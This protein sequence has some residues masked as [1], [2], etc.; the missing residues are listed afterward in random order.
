VYGYVTS[1]A[2]TVYLGYISAP[3]AITAY[4]EIAVVN[5][6]TMAMVSSHVFP[7]NTDA[8]FTDTFA[9]TQSAIWCGSEVSGNLVKFY[10]SSLSNRTVFNSGA[11]GG[12]IYCYEVYNDGRFLWL[13]FGG[14]GVVVRVDPFSG[15]LD[16]FTLPSS[17]VDVNSIWAD[18]TR[19]NLCFGNWTASGAATCV[20]SSTPLPPLQ[21]P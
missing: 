10:K 5:L 2:Q 16:P 9:L 11:F 8:G 21:Q 17:Q 15:D 4:L 12:G 19:Q 7:S 1:A 18:P 13:G 14:A 3:N 6:A 20:I